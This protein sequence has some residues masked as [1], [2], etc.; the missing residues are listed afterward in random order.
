M[1]GQD[2]RDPAVGNK[3]DG[4]ADSV[5]QAGAIHGDVHITHHVT[6]AGKKRTP[7]FG[8]RVKISLAL[9]GV[10]VIAVAA[11]LLVRANGSPSGTNG[12]PSVGAPASGTGLACAPTGSAATYPTSAATT[13]APQVRRSFEQADDPY[14]WGHAWGESLPETITTAHAYDGTHSLRIQV[15]PGQITALSTSLDANPANLDGLRPGGTVVAHIWYDGQG[16]GKIC[17]FVQGSQG[18]ASWIPV[19]EL[20]LTDESGHGWHDYTW[21]VPDT[22][23][24]GVGIQINNTGA[25]DLV[26]FLDAVSW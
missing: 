13:Q 1:T 4:G 22:P 14:T 15:S 24:K 20:A 6:A 7:R 3:V 2:P 23:F 11:V 5:V 25:T 10:I 9:G 12:S 21:R 16:A 8:N 17:P 18:G 19:K 26:L